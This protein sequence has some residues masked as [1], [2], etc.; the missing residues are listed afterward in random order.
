MYSRTR[1]KSLSCANNKINKAHRRPFNNNKIQKRFLMKISRSLLLSP[2]ASLLAFNLS[3][4]EGVQTLEKTDRTNSST[5]VSSTVIKS[6]AELLN[7]KPEALHPQMQKVANEVS[8]K[9]LI[10]NN[11]QLIQSKQSQ[12]EQLNSKQITIN[13]PGASFIKLHFKQLSLPSGVHLEVK[14][15]DGS[16]VHSYGGENPSLYTLQ[17]GDNGVTSFSALSVFG[18]TVIVEIIGNVSAKQAYHVEIDSLMEGIPEDQIQDFVPQSGDY[19]PESTCGVNERKDVQCYADSHPV[20]YERTRP[21]ARL[22]INGSGSCTAWRVGPDNRMFTNNHCISGASGPSKTEVWFNYQ[23]TGCNSGSSTSGRVIVTGDE[24]LQTN[25][26]LDYSLFTLKNFSQVQ[27]F[28][29]YGL[30]VRN[31]IQQERIYIPQHG[32]GDPKQLSIVSD[33]NSDGLCRVDVTLAD[34]SA[35]NTDM[36]YMCDTIGGSSGSPVLAASSNKAI[37]LHHFG[38]CPNQGVLINLIWPQVADFFGNVI[39]DGDNGSS[40]GDD[41]PV[42]SFNFEADALT[43]TFTDTSSDSDG[44]ITAYAWNF[45]DGSSSNQKNPVHTFASAGDYTVSLTVTDNDGNQSSNSILVSVTNVSDGQLVKGVEVGNLSETLNQEIR[46]YID[47]PENSRNLEF[48]MSG[49]TGDADLYVLYN[50]EPTTSE[51]DC[52][53]YKG[54]NAET[55]SFSSAR[56][57]RYHVMIKAY[58][59]FS[60]VNLIADYMESVPGVGFVETNLNASTGNWQHFTLDVPENMIELVSNISGG[61]GDA[62]IY[63]KF[64]SQPTTSSYD[65]RPYRNGNSETCS[66]NNP[67]AGTWYIS[68]RAYRGYSGV[69]LEAQAN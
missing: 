51:Y 42:A 8:L 30:D 68:I 37:A 3:A 23:K 2:I 60:G 39:P 49:G 5:V 4:S 13:K 21:V 11:K 31:P 57:G 19:Q 35:P 1:S 33:Q 45:G 55:C 52:R 32:R 7:A 62:D 10:T 29:Y 9:G 63:V 25:A 48:K 34:G 18:D 43:V 69:T 15:P 14:S 38:G 16:Q 40:G 58:R 22:L 36:G 50:E 54:G 64:G 59:G 47:V 44:T 26:D 53:P 17:D 28:G 61:S 56:A 46:F 24:M 6:G 67:Q 66:F 27:E 41:D 65:C 20:E 12:F